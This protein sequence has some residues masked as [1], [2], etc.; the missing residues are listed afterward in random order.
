MT[1]A[2]F[3]LLLLPALNDDADPRTL[4]RWASSRCEPAVS[5]SCGREP[6]GYCDASVG[7]CVCSPGRFGPRC[8]QMHYPA[9]RLHPDG[10]MACDTFVGLMSCACRLSC[11]QRYG[12]MARFNTPLCWDESVSDEE[13]SRRNLLG[14]CLVP[15]AV[16]SEHAREQYPLQGERAG[17][18]LPPPPCEPSCVCHRG[19]VGRA[20]EAVS[21]SEERE[22]FGASKYGSLCL[23]GRG[24]S[25]HG[26]CVARFCLCHAG[27]AGADCSLPNA[28][29]RPLAPPAALP[30][31]QPIG[32]RRV[33]I[34]IY[35]LPTEMSLEH[36]YMRDM[37]RRG[38]YYANLMFLEAL[39]RDKASV[40]ADPEQA[41]LF[42][43]PVMPMQ[44]AGNLWHPYEFLA[45]TAR[46]LA[47]E[48]PFWRRS[49]GRATSP[50]S[51][52]DRDHIFFLTTDRAGC[53]K[54]F[55]LNQSIANFGFEERLRWGANPSGP[56]RRNNAYDTREGSVAT[57]LPCYDVVVPV[58]TEVKAADQAKSPRPGAPYQCA[59]RAGKL[60]LLH[61]GGSMQNMGRIEYSQGVRQRIAE[62]HSDEPDFVLGGT[63]TLDD[64]R[65]A[66]FCLA[67]S[68]WGWGWRI[69]LTLLTQCVPVIIQPN[70][71]Q[72]F[73][74]LLPY[75]DF[76]LRLTKE[77]IPALPKLLRAVPDAT[78]CRM[79]TSLAK[80]YRALLWQKP[81]GPQHPSAYDLTMIALCRR[82]LRPTTPPLP[83]SWHLTPPPLLARRRAKS[84]AVR[85][86]R[87]PDTARAYL[88]RHTPEC[89]DTLEA[90]GVAFT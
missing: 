17:E 78:I 16:R 2:L 53:W 21:P 13:L 64:L 62:L 77:D 74:E 24:C 57:T 69:T 3:A 67:P 31:A 5:G 15:A 28:P 89:A 4:V 26:A 51:H 72:P 70:V 27:W 25:G 43:V 49:G 23:N 56:E 22:P 52:A 82:E 1:A 84:L 40:V 18:A 90:A 14:T 42:F 9:C 79:Q 83:A 76:S 68:G 86:S 48:Y 29:S 33:P 59:G 7:R 39:L 58:D 61:M 10:E 6:H 50:S 36:V 71:T 54:P 75:E 55:E 87:S 32:G 65:A 46:H 34:Y 73:E 19:Y 30:S 60:K 38:Q 80:H 41:A 8:E 20:C 37:L 88:A 11:E 12:S 81:H 47:S 35:P 63:F 45:Q 66:T 44:M 85:L